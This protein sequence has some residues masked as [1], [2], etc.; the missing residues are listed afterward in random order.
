MRKTFADAR[1]AVEKSQA[2][3]AWADQLRDTLAETL[4]LCYRN[5]L[6]HEALRQVGMSLRQKAK[7]LTQ[8][9]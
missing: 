7:N 2:L 8:K 3:I 4:D 1:Q 9:E 6:A 5:H